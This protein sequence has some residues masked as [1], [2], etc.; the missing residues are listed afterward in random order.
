MAR[1][2]FTRLT[3]GSDEDVAGVPSVDDTVA[4]TFS[5]TGV[6]GHIYVR[7]ANGVGDPTPLVTSGH[8]AHPNGWSPDGR[9]LLY[10]SHV[11]GRAQDL[12]LVGR[13]G[14]EP[15]A[16]LDT[17]ADESYG[18]FS[19][20]GRWIAYRSN[21]AGG[22]EIYVRDFVSDPAPAFGTR[23]VQISVNG[24]DK[25]RWSKDGKSLF[26]FEGTTLMQVS[27]D[28]ET[29]ASVEV[30]SPKRLFDI[31]L[32]AAS[33]YDVLPDGTFV[34]NRLIDTGPAPATPVRIVVNWTAL[35][36]R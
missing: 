25:P 2:A 36:R 14:G 4:Y 16:L 33:P 27:I 22:N 8:P 21:E 19:P 11:P 23:R 26:Y 3:P 28:T 6:A 7:A 9:F 35:L 32:K 18:L 31:R 1:K 17:A 20:N 30:G 24:G 29:A 15:V 13:E 5:S 12:L 34:M 10:D